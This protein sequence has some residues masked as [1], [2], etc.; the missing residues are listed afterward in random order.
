MNFTEF[1]KKNLVKE[2]GFSWEV[3][4]DAME[5]EHAIEGI[6]SLQEKINK[7]K[8]ADAKN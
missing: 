4:K 2:N 7:I 5:W 8:K 3:E 1:E 6:E